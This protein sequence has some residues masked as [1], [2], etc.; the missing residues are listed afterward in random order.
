MKDWEH[1]VYGEKKYNYLE[2]GLSLAAAWAWGVSIIVGMQVA[3]QRGALAFAIW[4]IA[5]SLALTLFG[6][7][8]S[9]M[10]INVLNST[11]RKVY[12]AL[13]I[14]I[15]FFS[16]LVNITAIKTAIIML[17]LPEWV[18]IVPVGILFITVF[19]G[20]YDISIKGDILQIICWMGIMLATVILSPKTKA[21]LP[22]SK[23]EDILW[24]LWGSLILFSG[25]IVDKQMWQRKAAMVMKNNFSVKSYIAGSIIFGLYM[26]FV[27][28]FAEYNINSAMATGLV[29]I[30]VAGST[31]QSAL[32]ALSTYSKNIKQGRLIMLSFFI[33]AIIC[34]I[35]NA[36]VL[37]IWTLYGS[38]RIPFA[39]YLVWRGLKSGR[40]YKRK[41]HADL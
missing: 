37:T 38:I 12:K 31:L 36:S 25:P 19:L 3:Q 4:A 21:M 30:L 28:M 6:L 29:I 27:Y 20:G 8:A 2:T 24:A 34:L 15:Q 9:K 41:I 5:N 35:F 11:E 1:F 39:I 14:A 32:S 7:V 18:W 22:V 26:L 40:A 23:R 10:D 33:L 16:V 17:N 13:M